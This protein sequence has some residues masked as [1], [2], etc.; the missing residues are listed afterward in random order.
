MGQKNSKANQIKHIS[1]SFTHAYTHNNMCVWNFTHIA[2]MKIKMKSNRINSVYVWVCTIKSTQVRV[3]ISA[4]ALNYHFVSTCSTFRNLTT[5]SYKYW[6][7][8]SLC[9]SSHTQ[10]HLHKYIQLKCIQLRLWS[11]GFSL[12]L[13]FY[14]YYFHF[15]TILN[16]I[17]KCTGK[18]KKRTSHA[19]PVSQPAKNKIKSITLI[20]GHQ[21]HLGSNFRS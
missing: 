15:A 4:T 8:P 3:Q 2:T 5:K 13:V 6:P 1:S 14:Y 9:L 10:T 16:L 21:I 17:T 7:K 18:K 12:S 19:K 20:N 11:V